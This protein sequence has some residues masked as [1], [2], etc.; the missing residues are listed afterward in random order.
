MEIVL[1]RLKREYNLELISSAPSVI[2]RIELMSGEEIEISN[3][4]DMPNSQEIS[5]IYEPMASGQIFVPKEYIGD[6]M[7]LCNKKRG[8][9]KNMTYSGNRVII[10]YDLPIGEIVL[11]FYDRLKSATKGYASFEYEFKNY[12]ESKL[13]KVDILLNAHIVDALSIICHKD[14]AYYKGKEL[15]DKIKE[16]IPRHMFDVPIQAAIGNKMIARETI[17]AMRKNVLSKCYGG[18]ITRKKKLLEKQKEG[19]K[20]MKSVGNVSIPQEAFLSVL[21]IT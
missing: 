16:F 11:D 3:P 1:E 15:V 9:F 6:V 12:A 13:V 4:S 20:R 17:K 8:V 21:K 14:Q 10:Y 19:K 5:K 18:D 7:Q 2:Y